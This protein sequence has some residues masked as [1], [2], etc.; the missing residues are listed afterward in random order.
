MKALT[1]FLIFILYVQNL[2]AND[3]FISQKDISI[4][5]AS[6]K[7]EYDGKI[8][9]INQTGR[10]IFEPQ[11]IIMQSGNSK[12][13]FEINKISEKN[14]FLIFD[15]EN[16]RKEKASFVFYFDENYIIKVSAD[17]LDMKV[18]FS[19]GKQPILLTKVRAI[20]NNKIS[21]Q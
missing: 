16:N 12:E 10:I 18:N 1:I 7:F 20:Y 3:N 14:H 11:R 15:T 9:N 17:M 13:A 8:Q 5:F 19:I 21:S 6:M 2:H 4:L